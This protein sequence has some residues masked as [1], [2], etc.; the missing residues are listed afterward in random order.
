MR[1]CPSPLY[2]FNSVFTDFHA[3]FQL[4]EFARENHVIGKSKSPSHMKNEHHI[5]FFF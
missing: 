3:R 4:A 5:K 1:S 2:R